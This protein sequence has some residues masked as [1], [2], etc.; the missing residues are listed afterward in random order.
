MAALCWRPLRPFKRWKRSLLICMSM[1]DSKILKTPASLRMVRVFQKRRVFILSFNRPWLFSLRSSYPYQRTHSLT[2]WLRRP[3][4]RSTSTI[5]MKRHAC[6][7]TPCQRQRKSCWQWP[8][9]H[10]VSLIAS[11]QP[12]TALIYSLVALS[13]RQA[14]RSSSPPH[15]T[16]PFYT[17][18]IGGS[19]KTPGP[20]YSRV[21]RHSII[22]LPPTTKGTSKAAFFSHALGGLTRDCNRPL[23]PMRF[24]SKSSIT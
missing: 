2:M 10:S 11:S 21:T 8:R 20:S 7:L 15:D 16:A 6:A 17:Q 18:R 24:P 4:S 1:P 22:P 14:S 3:A 19:E 13:M 9:I 12:S 5:W 23:T